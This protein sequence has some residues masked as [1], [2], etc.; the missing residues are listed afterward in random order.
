MSNYWRNKQLY[1]LLTGKVRNTG[2]YSGTFYRLHFLM[3]RVNKIIVNIE[4]WIYNE[5]G[6]KPSLKECRR[7][8]FWVEVYQSDTART[9]CSVS[10]WYGT[11]CMQ[12]ISLIRYGLYAVH[13]SDS[14]RTV[15]S[16][17]VW[18]GTG[19]MQCIGLI[20]HGLYSV[21]RSDTARAVCSVSVWYGTGCMQCIGLIQHALYA[22]YRSNTVGLYAVY[23][24]DTAR[25][26]CSISI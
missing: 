6:E 10:V 9:V 14:A 1:I 2:R 19:C 13:Q 18:Y 15:C 12:C 11:D 24:S 16:V 21:Y 5:S 22:V 25:A 4:P 23:R 8:V 7:F 20:R 26:V 3:Y 17:S